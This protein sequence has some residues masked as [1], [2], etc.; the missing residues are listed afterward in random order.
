MTVCQHDK[1]DCLQVWQACVQV[2]QA[3][4]A[5]ALCW[6]ADHAAQTSTTDSGRSVQDTASD[7]CAEGPRVCCPASASCP[8]HAAQLQ[9]FVI[10][11]HVASSD[12]R[13]HSALV[14]CNVTITNGS[15]RRLLRCELVSSPLPAC[16]VQP[17][18]GGKPRHLLPP[19]VVPSANIPTA[20]SDNR[21]G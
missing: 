19:C 13:S 8:G 21:R 2:R 10:I 18:Y 3:C 17:E 11:S 9:V 4:I 14:M 16:G 7:C 12:E 20:E 6:H 1:A 5:Q 15:R